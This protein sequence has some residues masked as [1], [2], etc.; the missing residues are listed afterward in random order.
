[1]GKSN[2]ECTCNEHGLG[3]RTDLV[4]ILQKLSQRR[5]TLILVPIVVGLITAAL[6]SLMPNIYRAEVLLSPVSDVGDKNKSSMISQFSG[7]ASLAGVSLGGNGSTEENLAVLNSKIFLWGFIEKNNLI[8]VLFARKWDASQNKWKSKEGD[9]NPTLWDAYRLLSKDG[10]LLV[11]QEKKSDLVRIVIEW[12]DPVL[13]AKWANLLV[14]Q[15]NDFLRMQAIERSQNNLKYL[16]TELGVT[17]EYE[18]R[19]ALF[20]LISQEKKKIM[21]ASTQRDYAFKVI[22]S[23]VAPDQKIKPKRLLIVVSTMLFSFL[24]VLMWVLLRSK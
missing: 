16:A 14:A 1:M 23:A 5:I 3:G 8:P 22:D 4:D 24:F 18:V 11:Q 13:A 10:V 7:L 2:S 12:E 17:Q 21:L 15:L 6:T 20:D 9:K 19:Q